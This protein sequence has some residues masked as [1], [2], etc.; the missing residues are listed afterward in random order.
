MSIMSMRLRETRDTE[1]ILERLP[2]ELRERVLLKAVQK[3]G[4]AFAQEV[5]RKYRKLDSD[6]WGKP[7]SEQPI[8]KSVRRVGI[9]HGT[10]VV[11]RVKTVGKANL[12]VLPL[13]YGHQKWI[14]G[15]ERKDLGPVKERPVFRQTED[16]LEQRIKTLVENFARTESAKVIANA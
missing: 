13:E 1:K 5:R 3:G 15:V 11:S 12:Y 6:R 16:E 4:I 2:I 8:A 10:K 14:F 7:E 9:A